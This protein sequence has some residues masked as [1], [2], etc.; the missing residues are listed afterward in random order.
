MNELVAALARLALV[1]QNAV[2]GAGRAE[3]LAFVQQG[4]LNGCGRTV[5]K[6]L[7]V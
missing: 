2:H 1:F 3:V 5:L 4:G 7:F 6:P